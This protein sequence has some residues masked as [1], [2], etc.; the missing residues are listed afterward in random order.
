MASLF[1][2]SLPDMQASG[3]NDEKED[4]E[5][6]LLVSVM[7]NSLKDGIHGGHNGMA[8]A[9]HP[10][11]PKSTA[12]MQ[13]ETPENDTNIENQERKNDTSYSGIIL[14]VI[15]ALI[16][17]TFT[18][19]LL[20]ALYRMCFKTA[21]E[22]QE[23]GTEQNKILHLPQVQRNGTAA[24]ACDFLSRDKFEEVVKQCLAWGLPIDQGELV[25]AAQTIGITLVFT[26]SSM[27]P[28][29]AP[30]DKENVK[31]I[32]VKTTSPE[33]GE[34]SSQGKNKTRLHDDSSSHLANKRCDGKE[35]MAHNKPWEGNCPPALTADIEE[36]ACRYV[37][38]TAVLQPA[39]AR[40]SWQKFTGKIAVLGQTANVP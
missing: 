22:R 11:T 10:V 20:M 27:S 18:V 13:P 32:S 6:Q 4:M 36:M 30:L 40:N 29:R 2:G 17:I 1:S 7:I 31:L 23:N 14:P 35:N 28:Y 26:N 12:V 8:T 33:I 38:D 25:T 9:R 24:L 5:K 37:D 16:V 19:F 39:G 21:P 34:Q 3:S 15:I